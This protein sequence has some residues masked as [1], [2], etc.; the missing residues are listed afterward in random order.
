M[1][2]LLIGG[3]K[4]RTTA[5]KAMAGALASPNQESFVPAAEMCL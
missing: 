4:I 1:L 5:K 3:P 2:A